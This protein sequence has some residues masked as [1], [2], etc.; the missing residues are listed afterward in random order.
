MRS[1]PARETR[2]R[3]SPSHPDLRVAVVILAAGAGRRFGSD[4][5]LYAI[6]GTPMLAC[7]LSVY[8]AVFADV[9]VVIRPGEAAIAALVR[10]ADCRVVEATEA[11]RGQSQSLAAGVQAMRGAD[12]LVVGLGD[13]PFVQTATLR[14]LVAAMRSYPEHIVR[15][16]HAGCPGNPIGFPASYFSS[17]TNIAGDIGARDVVARSDKVFMFDTKDAG[18]LED[19]DRPR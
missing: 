6:T 13:M 2:G 4:K 10:A 16:S 15:P 14:A 1:P 19:V 11:A 12:A 8:R 9:G 7:T 18:V 17:L 3:C 5:R